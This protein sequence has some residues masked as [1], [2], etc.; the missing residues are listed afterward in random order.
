LP[1]RDRF[2]DDAAREPRPNPFHLGVAEPVRDRPARPARTGVPVGDLEIALRSPRDLDQ[3][4]ERLLQEALEVALPTEPQQPE[5][6]VP[7]SA[8]LIEVLDLQDVA[9]VNLNAGPLTR[10]QMAWNS[11]CAGAD[12]GVL[13]QLRCPVDPGEWHRI[14]DRFFQILSDG[15]HRF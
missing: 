2:G 15:V 8:D 4:S 9:P 14:M 5:I 3:K 6:E 10:M 12:Y 7:L 1:G 13:R 11:L